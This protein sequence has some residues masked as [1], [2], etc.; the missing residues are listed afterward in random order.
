MGLGE[1]WPEVRSSFVDLGI[2]GSQ[3]AFGSL[4]SFD[5]AQGLN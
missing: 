3:G 1:T 2:F 4:A 5:R